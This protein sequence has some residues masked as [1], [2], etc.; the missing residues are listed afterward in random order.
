MLMMFEDFKQ[1]MKQS[2]NPGSPFGWLC[3]YTPEEILHAAGFTPVGIRK[4]SG[5]E[6]EDVYLGRNM[7]SYVHSVFGGALSGKYSGMEGVV[8]AHGCECLRRLYDGW[9]EWNSMLN[10]SFAYQLNVPVTCNDLSIDYFADNLRSFI[11]T[12]EEKFSVSITGEK[13]LAS[14]KVYDK[15]RSLL[16]RLASLREKN[17]P[18]VSGLQVA[19]ILDIYMNQSKESFN[20]GFEPLLLEM[21]K[22]ESGVFNTP[23][24]RIMVYGGIHNPDLIRYIEREDTG[25]IVVCED[26]CSGLR[27]YNMPPDTGKNED[28]VHSLSR[29]YLSKMPCPRMSGAIEDRITSDLLE[30]IKRYRVEGVIYYITKYCENH[31]WEYPFIKELLEKN[32]IPLKRIEGDVAGDIPEREIK[33][34]IE[35][36][37]F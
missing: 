19:E 18:P 25:G 20:A 31:Y 2:D 34:F 35:L 33:S 28:P 37:N 32:N 14:I 6:D 10:P 3:T 23:R 8:I 21:E 16:N 7:C 11:K 15:T 36:I 22:S 5:C 30:L 24:S 1:K 4:S 29:R 13:L 9:K 12:L 17:N 26:T 27:Y